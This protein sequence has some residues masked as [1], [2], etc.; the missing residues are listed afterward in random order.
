MP[1]TR[2]L[3]SGAVIACLLLGLAAGPAHAADPVIAAAGDIACDPAGASFNNG[4]GSATLCRQ[5][6]TSNLLV[7][8]DLS[9]VLAVGDNQYEDGTLAQFQG[10][11][12]PSWGRVKSITRPV[13]GNHEYHISPDGYFD[14]FNGVGS[15]IGP[16]GERGKGYYSFDVGAWHLVALNS[17][18]DQ[19]GGCG[20]GSPQEQ[21]LRADL[22]A[23]A[24]ASCTLAYWHH[25]LYNS[26]PD[27]NYFDTVWN[28]AGLWQALYESGAELVFSGHSHAY[29]RFGPQDGAGHADAQ[30]G[31][32]QFIVGTGGKS[33]GNNGTTQPNSQLRDNTQYGV[34]KLVLHPNGYDFAFVND[35]GA[36]TDL[37]SSSC[38]GNRPPDTSISS[39]PSGRVNTTSPSFSFASSE[40]GSTFRCTLNG[41]GSTIGTETSC[42]SPQPYSGLANGAYTFS[43]YAVDAG[44]TADATPAT[45]SFTVDTVAPDT[46]ITSASVKKNSATFSFTSTEAGSRFTCRLDTGSPV[47]CTSPRT[48]SGLSAGQHTFAVFATDVAGNADTSPATRAVTISKGGA[49]SASRFA[50]LALPF[51]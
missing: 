47:S 21:W 9:A 15:A 31:V 32:R 30:Y 3:A 20:A 17:M 48:Y 11:Y 51:E 18:C 38:H 44:G 13:I 14:Y 27:G 16:A 29:E 1:R 49:K 37:G 19:V 50:S 28:T 7:G 35:S 40:P 42:S 46:S 6:Y 10:S 24:A 41:P 4:D 43:V 2:L 25:P 45:R 39:G 34:V 23:N 36:T 8:A 26:G 33:L 12:D 5:K 22:A